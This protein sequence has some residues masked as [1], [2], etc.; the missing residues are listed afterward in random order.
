MQEPSPDC[1]LRRAKL[2]DWGD[3]TV[4]RTLGKAELPPEPRVGANLLFC[5]LFYFRV[6][7]AVQKGGRWGKGLSAHVNVIPVGK[8]SE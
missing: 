7:G 5:S 4:N 8:K 6:G 3:R 1:G 2:T